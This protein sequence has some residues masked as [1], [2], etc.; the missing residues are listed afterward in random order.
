[1]TAWLTAIASRGAVW[2]AAVTGIVAAVLLE[3]SQLFITSRMPGLADV[4]VRAAGCATGVLLERV[5]SRRP[6]PG[7]W[8]AL[9]TA[10]IVAGAAL[11]IWS[12]SHDQTT[13]EAIGRVFEQALIYF[14]L[15]FCVVRLLSPSGSE[16][17][18]ASLA[19]GLAVGLDLIHGGLGPGVIAADAA[20]AALGAGLGAR[21]GMW[22]MRRAGTTGTT[23]AG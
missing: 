9:I 5:A 11:E 22:A 17:A 6:A 4:A 23:G 19:V 8:F 12:P 14:P 15:G 1:L 16:L 20:S 10:A 13:L 2:R 7:P 21:A 3:A 18:S